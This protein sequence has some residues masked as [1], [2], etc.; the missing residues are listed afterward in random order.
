VA[1]GGGGGGGGSG[2]DGEVRR[3]IP[4]R[5]FALLLL[6]LGSRSPFFFFRGWVADRPGA[7]FPL[8]FDLASPALVGFTLRPVRGWSDLI[9]RSALL[10]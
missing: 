4:G 2:S 1:G 5:W 3:T 8:R 10:D 7:G 6:V 9:K